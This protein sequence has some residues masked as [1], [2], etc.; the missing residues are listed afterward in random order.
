MK[1]TSKMGF[2]FFIAS[3]L[4]VLAFPCNPLII[5][6]VIDPNNIEV[7]LYVGWIFIAVSITL[8]S[9]SYYSIFFRKLNVLI[10]SG[11]YAIVRHPMYLG[12]ILG[13]FVATIFLYQHWIFVIIGIPG[14][15]S[16]YL[17]S[18]QEEQRNIGR[19]GDDYKHYMQ[20]VPRMNLV[21][22]IIRQVRRRKKNEN[23]R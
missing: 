23:D 2:L 12:W 21:V 22:G 18:R 14:I 17:I 15:A 3:I 1:Q 13:I 9:L 5:F 11:I 20:K 6:K 4:S 7:L 16:L 8:I 10:D 19:F